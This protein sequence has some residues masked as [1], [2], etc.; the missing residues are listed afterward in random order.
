MSP[1][2]FKS[3]S[4]PR[5]LSQLWHQ[6]ARQQPSRREHIHGRI[7]AMDCRCSVCRKIAA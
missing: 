6:I 4:D 2:F 3:S 1:L 7:H 5:K